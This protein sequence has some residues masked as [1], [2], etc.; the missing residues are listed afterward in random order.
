MSVRILR[1]D[2]RD[3][4]RTLPDESVHCVVSS[5]PYWGL[6]DYGIPPSIWGGDPGHAHEWGAEGSR[7][8]GG[9]PGDSDANAG[10]D[11]SAQAATGDVLTGCFCA[12]GAWRGALGLEPD[13]YLFVANMV[14]VFREVW[15]VLRPDGTLFLNLGDSYWTGGSYD[16]RS[17]DARRRAPHASSCDISD[18]GPADY[19]ARGCLCGS[20]CGVCREVYRRSTRNDPLLESMLRA[21]IHES[22]PERMASRSVPLPTSDSSVP[23]IRTADAIPGRALPSGHADE[24][25]RASLVSMLGESSPLLQAE[26]L[27][28]AKGGEC[29]LCARSLVGCAP[30]SVH[31][32]ECN[33][34]IERTGSESRRSG[35]GVSGSA[36]P[37]STIASLKAKDLVG[38][39][40]RV[41][42]ALQED[43]WWLR[44]DIV[45]AKPNPMPESVTDRCTKSHEYLFHLSKSQRYYFDQDAILEP[46]SQNTH[47]RLSQDV[48]NQVGSDQAVGKTNGKMKAVG[49]DRTP[50][51]WATGTDRSEHNNLAG[52]YTGHRKLA[53]ADSGIKQNESF[54][55]AMRLP[56]RKSG[57]KSRQS[58]AERGCPEGSGANVCS[59]VPWEGY[60]RNKRSVWTVTTQPFKEA[61]FAT[62]PA[63]LVEPCIL[64][65][66]SAHGCCP[67]C[68]AGWKRILT[69]SQE[70]A[71]FKKKERERKG[72]GMRS[73]DLENYGSSGGTSNKSVSA[74][75]LTVGWY[76]ACRCDGLPEFP[77]YPRKPA[78]DKLPAWV[79]TCRAIDQ[80]RV[81]LCKLA[82]PTK[83]VPAVVLDP[84]GGAGTTGLVA[85]RHHRDA[86]LCELNP[87]YADMAERRIL[88][89]APLFAEVTA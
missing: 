27:R 37:H 13:P 12:C 3:L 15:R 45:W 88:G 74:E 5:P 39:P 62:F 79:E 8:R 18:R 49:R 50:A 21:S 25:L 60:E 7:H 31:T 9:P 67:K 84:F 28:R 57:N 61:H 34:G 14:E 85:D 35:T 43:G 20:L 82:A 1:G 30:A 87:Q 71:E 4:L 46:I 23:A 68:G 48:L 6:R 29:L 58:G 76:P 16:V 10:R 78:A 24:L 51:G 66:T 44:Q 26:C 2:C 77:A 19:L 63:K 33:C 59:H 22:T 55:N 41:A 64:A 36:Y 38:V 54:D 69:D 32:V 11:R 73:S 70:Y 83:V 47:L 40:W 81:E 80:Q 86:I 53:A 56:G 52:N 72:T 65:G 75:H 89:D 17:R 42:F